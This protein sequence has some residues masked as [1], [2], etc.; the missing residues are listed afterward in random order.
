MKAQLQSQP[1]ESCTR[2]RNSE[3]AGSILWDCLPV[4]CFGNPDHTRVRAV[5]VSLNPSSLEF[6]DTGGRA[7]PESE[8]LPMVGDFKRTGRELLSSDDRL[9]ARATRDHYFANKPHSW[10]TPMQ[11]LLRGLNLGWSYAE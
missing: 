11:I 8:R 2:C 4:P 5:T 10:F 3:A 6:F 1:I 9:R 7:K